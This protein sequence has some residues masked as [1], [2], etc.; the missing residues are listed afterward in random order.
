MMRVLIEVTEDCISK[1][2]YGDASQCPIALAAHKVINPYFAVRAKYSHLVVYDP[3][4]MHM[5]IYQWPDTNM[6]YKIWKFNKYN[7]MEPFSFWL[8]VD[9]EYLRTA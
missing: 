9:D 1:G 2:K 3:N 5:N 7:T 6:G 8:D 4:T